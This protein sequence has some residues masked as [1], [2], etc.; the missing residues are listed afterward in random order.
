MEKRIR[1]GKLCGERRERGKNSSNAMRNRKKETPP[2]P[3]PKKN[4]NHPIIMKTMSKNG[5]SKIYMNEGIEKWTVTVNMVTKEVTTITRS[6]C[7]L[8]YV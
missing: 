3:S 1:E 4:K 8:S 6:Q 7:D 2:P 5:N